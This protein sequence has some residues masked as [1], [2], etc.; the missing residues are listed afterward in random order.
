MSVLPEDAGTRLDL[1]LFKKGIAPSRS[2]GQIWIRDELVMRAEKILKGNYKVKAG[3]IIV[4][5]KPF[6]QPV[7]I[8]PEDIPLAIVYEDDDLVVINKPAGL[9]VHPA[10]GNQTGTL[11]NALLYHIKDLSGINGEIRPGIVHRIDK[12]TSGLLVVA[13]NDVAHIDLAA[14]VKEH[15]VKREYLALVH[16]IVPSETGRIDAP[17][18]RD[19]RDRQKMAVNSKGKPAVTHF[20]VKERFPVQGGFSL[21][22]CTLETGRTHQIRVHMAYIDHPVAGDPK[23]GPRKSAF[24]LTGQALHAWRLEF[25]HP[26][27]KKLMSFEQ[28]PPE[29][30]QKLL[31]KLRQK[32]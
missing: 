4:V 27:H 8:G 6:P 10:E 16:G 19:L 7:E 28:E 25:Q 5:K 21:I 23:Y 24:N 3:D 13:K 18:G 9:V 31:G 30:F 17:I 22:H 29:V 1:W 2:H 11:V 14:Q 20:S 15:Q 12:D 26:R 32:D